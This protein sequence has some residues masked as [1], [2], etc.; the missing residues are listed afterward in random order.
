MDNHSAPFRGSQRALKMLQT[1]QMQQRALASDR[2][3]VS[4]PNVASWPPKP[5]TITSLDPV[6]DSTLAAGINLLQNLSQN[7]SSSSSISIS[8]ASIKYPVPAIGNAVAH[9]PVPIH[10]KVDAYASP[11]ANIPSNGGSSNNLFALRDTKRSTSS[12]SLGL[13]QGSTSSVPPLPLAPAPAAVH[14]TEPTIS[15]IVVVN[16]ELNAENSSTQRSSVPAVVV[17][18]SAKNISQSL[19]TINTSSSASS[20]CEDVRSGMCYSFS[21]GKVTSLVSTRDGAYCVAGFS[22]GAIRLYDLTKEGNTD[23][24]DRFGYQIGSL[25]SSSRAIQVPV[26][27]ANICLVLNSHAPSCSFCF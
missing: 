1:T 11:E 15:E 6:S 25:P 27:A 9:S 8:S 22:T 23:P 19:T 14:S 26:L 7:L 5:A 10:R 21:D 24:E 12:N 18:N 20:E 13:T 2:S 16:P 3:K 17:S 4:N